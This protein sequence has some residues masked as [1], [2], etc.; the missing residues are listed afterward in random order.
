VTGRVKTRGKPAPV[1]RTGDIRN[2]TR[3]AK[4]SDP[5]RHSLEHYDCPQPPA[6]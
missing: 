3:T 4:S 1:S 2:G 6:R 5:V